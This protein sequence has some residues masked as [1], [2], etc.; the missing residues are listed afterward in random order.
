VHI[1]SGGPLDEAV[2]F[3][4]IKTENQPKM[5]QETGRKSFRYKKKKIITLMISPTELFSAPQGT[6]VFSLD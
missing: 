6:A 1:I 4:E 3:A 5:Q 2:V